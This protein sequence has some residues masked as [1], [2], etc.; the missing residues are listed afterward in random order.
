MVDYK[1]LRYEMLTH[2]CTTEEL[3]KVCNISMSSFYRRIKGDV[4]FTLGEIY[5]CKAR[6]DLSTARIIQIFFV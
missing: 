6:L 5:Q 1:A 2:N 4:S 3:A